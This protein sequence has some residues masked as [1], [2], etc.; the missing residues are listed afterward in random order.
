[1]PFYTST[2][3]EHPAKWDGGPMKL[4]AGTKIRFYCDYDNSTGSAE[5]FQGQSAATNEMCMFTGMYYPAMDQ[6]SEYCLSNFDQFGVG[7]ATCAATS[8][9]IQSC[10]PGS[11][12]TGLGSG[13][14]GSADVSPCWQKCLVSSC[15][16]ASTPLFAQLTCIGT[17]CAT[18]CSGTGS[19]CTGCAVQKCPNEVTACQSAACN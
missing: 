16:A 19:G 11:A 15:P 13:A 2:D 4:T 9:C 8:N 5:Y 1:M 7:T 12:P 6:A 14:S 3:W 17:R 18:E 10:P